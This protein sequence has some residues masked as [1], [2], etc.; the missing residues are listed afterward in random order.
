MYP[1]SP[2]HREKINTHSAI[3]ID[4][5]ATISK[6]LNRATKISFNVILLDFI[7][8]SGS[9]FQESSACHSMD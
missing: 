2:I 9:A 8:G 1:S 3:G 7:T 5:P 6:V 4:T